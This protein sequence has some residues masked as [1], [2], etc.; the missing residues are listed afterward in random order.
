MLP[1]RIHGIIRLDGLSK[2]R[3]PI[4][5]AAIKIPHFA[6]I[7]KADFSPLSPYNNAPGKCLHISIDITVLPVNIFSSKLYLFIYFV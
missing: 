7:W 6:N 3:F 1:Y 5:R 2:L 4:E